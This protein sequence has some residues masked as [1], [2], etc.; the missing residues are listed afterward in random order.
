MP[1]LAYTDTGKGQTI[2]FIHGFC[3]NKSI[4]AGIVKE[5]SSHFRCVCIDL[6]GFGASQANKNQ[7][8]IAD[9]ASQVYDFIQFHALKD[10]VVIG[11]SLGGYVSLEL[12]H[13]HPDA[14]K[15]FG[16]F[17]S[18]SFADSDE[19]KS[20][21]NKTIA[22]VEKHGVPPIVDGFVDSLFYQK[23]RERLESEVETVKAMASETKKEVHIAYSA[24]MRDRPDLSHLLSEFGKPVLLIA[25]E[26]DAAVPFE[27]SVAQSKMAQ[28]LDF[29]ALENVGHMGMIEAPDKCTEAIRRFVENC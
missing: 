3:E 7:F 14:L 20:N 4:W 15:G 27:S 29:V 5:L 16:L 23:N 17:H 11:H 10:V 13:Q 8:S 24:A 1:S 2:L 12:A 9:I 22:F 26:Q 19:K 25:G 18:T 28:L 21:R 6:P